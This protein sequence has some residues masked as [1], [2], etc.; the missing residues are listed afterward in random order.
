MA[1]K[2]PPG[3]TRTSTQ[4]RKRARKLVDP[5]VPNAEAVRE[6]VLNAA[7]E[8]FGVMGFDGTSISSVANLCSV[9][10]ALVHYH[11]SSKADLWK[12]AVSHGV[13]DMLREL[14]MSSDDMADLDPITRL[15]FLI[16][17]YINYFARKPSIF[18]IIVKES[19]ISSP[20]FEWLQQNHLLPMYGPWTEMFTMLRKA[21]L[22]RVSAADYHLALITVGACLHFLSSRQR[23][24][25]IYGIDPL[26]P[27]LVRRHADLVV[28]ILITG[29]TKPA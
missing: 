13:A 25:P 4:P 20:R 16:R 28:D 18:S 23:I 21:E 3:T 5:A 1:A 8:S 27:E 29:L 6:R 22:L 24:L 26:Q 12:E 2:P 9:S 11:F 14:S 17:R 10:N 15:K 19:D 7:L